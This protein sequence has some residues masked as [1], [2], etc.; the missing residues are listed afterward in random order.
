VIGWWVFEAGRD[1]PDPY[2]V[3]ASVLVLVIYL[4]VWIKIKRGKR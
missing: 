4:A 1:H 3:G 2:L